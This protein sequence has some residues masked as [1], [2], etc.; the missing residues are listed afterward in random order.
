MG[1]EGSIIPTL[2]LIRRNIVLGIG[3]R[4]DFSAE[5]M[6]QTVLKMLKEY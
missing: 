5:K 2:K 4:K 1:L 3:C 6:Q